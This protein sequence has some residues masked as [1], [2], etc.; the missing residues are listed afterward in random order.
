MMRFVLC[1][2]ILTL[3]VEVMMW[4]V[5]CCCAVGVD[6]VDR[7]VAW[8]PSMQSAM[9]ESNEQFQKGNRLVEEHRWADAKAYY[10]G[11]VKLWPLHSTGASPGCLSIPPPSHSLAWQRT[12]TWEC[13]RPDC[14][15]GRQQWMRKIIA[16]A[17][18]ASSIVN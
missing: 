14:G 15:T 12:R 5:L 4:V 3:E 10:T 11:A 18:A 8:H 6:M 13:W 2:L 9:D 1:L 7:P 16:R 17:A